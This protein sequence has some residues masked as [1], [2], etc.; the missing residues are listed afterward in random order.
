M[1]KP[2]LS[3]RL[4][5]WQWRVAAR[6]EVFNTE[7]ERVEAEQNEKCKVFTINKNECISPIFLPDQVFLRKYFNFFLS[8]KNMSSNRV[9]KSVIKL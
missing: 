2:V 1:S 8:I 9:I 5:T 3:R 6:Q 7:K 4:R